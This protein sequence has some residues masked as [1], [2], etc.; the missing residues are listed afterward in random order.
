MV[1]KFLNEKF[2]G[3]RTPDRIFDSRFPWNESVFVRIACV[4]DNVCGYLK[5]EG[6]TKSNS[7]IGSTNPNRR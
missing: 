3:R 6:E 4:F 1:R 7:T 5:S 2:E